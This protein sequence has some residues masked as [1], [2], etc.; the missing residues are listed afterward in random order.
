[1]LGTILTFI[2]VIA[3]GCLFVRFYAEIFDFIAYVL[4][5]LRNL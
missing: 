4:K 2:V 3:I 5:K 1:M